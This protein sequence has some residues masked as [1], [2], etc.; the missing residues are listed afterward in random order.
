MDKMDNQIQYQIPIEH[1][2][3]SALRLYCSNRWQFKKNYI[4]NQWDNQSSSTQLAGKGFHT[5]MEHHLM[6][7]PLEKAIQKGVEKVESVPDREIDFGK[8]GSREKVLK[9]MTSGVNFYLEELPVFGKILTT[10]EKIT[11][12]VEING[13]RL[14]L[15]IKAVTDV[16][17]EIDHKIHLHDHKLVTAFTDKEEEMP[18]Y[19]M[20]AVFN[21][22]TVKTK[23]K[24]EPVAMHFHEV[25]KSRNEDNSPQ[26]QTYTIEFAR[27]PEY[28]TYF[29]KIYT[30]LLYE[31]S[32]PDVQF[33]PN[34]SDYMNKVETWKDFTAEIMDFSLPKQISHKTTLT[35]NVDK[36]YNKEYVESYT[37]MAENTE[38]NSAELIISKYQEF[39]V[40][41]KFERQY[42]GANFSMYT[43]KPSRGV[44]MNKI[45]NLADD[46]AY[47]LGAESVRVQAPIFGTKTIGV[48]VSN[49]KQKII[50]LQLEDPRTRMH[51]QLD[52]PIGRDVYGKDISI[53]LEKAPHILVA[54]ATGAG[55]SVF[56]NCVVQTLTHYQ[57]D[58]LTIILIDPKMTEFSQYANSAKVHTDIESISEQ[59]EFLIEEMNS[60]YAVFKEVSK[61]NLSEYNELG[62]PLPKI[63]V[64]ID[65][66][67]D[68]VLSKETYEEVNASGTNVIRKRYATEIEANLIRLAQKSRAAG[69]HII[70]ATQR[71]SVDV[72]T[73]VL[74]AN[75]PTRVAFRTATT[76]DSSVILDSAGA[77][78]LIGN[79]DLLLM[80]P[81]F[82]SLVRLQGYY[83]N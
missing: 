57:D 39:G 68:L 21:Y 65:E 64:I 4:L 51:A 27:H 73:G 28:V 61:K 72:V 1:I 8:T 26:V 69:I 16:V 47:A 56:L 15:P 46:V 2:S 6:G 59:L 9:D 5:V 60:R 83:A 76:V 50:T 66:L 77:E 31:L 43:F 80:S 71:P 67:A 40:P 58:N 49:E 20:Q 70:A 13:Q 41:M 54:G 81:K 29:M 33:L 75:F 24:N 17:S 11:A 74:K 38:L 55:K 45:A 3:Y 62:N 78:K 10:E 12:E 36:T 44:L 32:N 53:D 7:L 19:I 79:G 37:D 30:G 63:V 18:D 35:S 23:Y 42:D 82:K 52:I 48:E 22:L 14:P 34:F 25:K